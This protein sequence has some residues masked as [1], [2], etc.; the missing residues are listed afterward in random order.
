MKR[1]PPTDSQKDIET[2][3]TGIRDYMDSLIED[4]TSIGAKIEVERERKDQLHQARLNK[5]CDE[6]ERRIDRYS[7]E[8]HELG[9]LRRR[10][11]LTNDQRARLEL[12]QKLG[13]GTSSKQ[14][15]TT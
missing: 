8:K 10:N 15:R 6:L 13:L 9:E 1:N 4:I 7:T 2:I 11:N 12:R 14:D 3:A 5:L